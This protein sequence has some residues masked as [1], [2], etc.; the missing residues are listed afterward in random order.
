MYK[1]SANPLIYRDTYNY[2]L[3]EELIAQYPLKDRDHSRL[4][5]LKRQTG[6]IDHLT[7]DVLPDLLQPGDVLVF[8]ETK[9][10]SARLKGHKMSGGKAEIFLLNQKDDSHWE[11]LVKPGRRLQPGTVVTFSD[12]FKA[13]II[14]VLEDGGRLVKFTWE[15]DFWNTL[16]VHGQIPLPPYVHREPEPSDKDHYQTVYA[17]TYGSVAAHTAGL[18]FTQEILDKLSTKGVE[19]TFVNLRVGL[20]TFRPVKTKR[21]DQHIMHREYCEISTHTANIVNKALDQ[22][23]RVIAVG[24]TSTRTLESFAENGRVHSGGHFTDIFIYPGGRPIQIISGLITNFHMPK[25]TLLM[26]VSAFAGYE[27]IMNAYKIAVQEKYRFF[28]YGD[29]MMIL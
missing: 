23:R 12:T 18:H 26:L 24:T 14:N 2:E 25:S 3:P 29:A 21:I 9:V 7:F 15:G 10:I 22:G 8:N 17:R 6:H 20:G 4:L 1:E 27:N 19:T 16:E 13:E 28:S 11:C 5:T